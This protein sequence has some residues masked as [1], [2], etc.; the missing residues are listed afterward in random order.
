MFGIT[1][2][3]DASFRLGIASNTLSDSRY[4][5]EQ[6]GVYSS[7]GAFITYSAPL[8]V[9]DLPNMTFFDISGNSGDYFG[10][11]VYTTAANYVPVGLIT[12]DAIPEP[13]TYGLLVL[14]IICGLVSWRKDARVLRR[15]P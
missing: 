1:L 10:I 8:T 3:S 12:F 13:S 4:G 14:A 11:S 6:I 5:A 15:V 2:T 9:S 7:T